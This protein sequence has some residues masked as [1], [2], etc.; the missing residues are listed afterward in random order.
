MTQA[1]A[2]ASL[3]PGDGWKAVARDAARWLAEG[4]RSGLLL[5]SRVAGEAAPAV[6]LAVALAYAALKL[7]LDRLEIVGPAQFHLR[8]WLAPHW[9]N[10][11]VAV[12]M[13]AVLWRLPGDPRRPRGLGAWFTLYFASAIPASRVGQG[14]AIAAAREALPGFLDHPVAGWSV[15]AV[16]L[17]WDT[18]VTLWLGVQFGLRRWRLA[19]AVGGWLALFALSVWQGDDHAWYPAPSARDQ[20]PRL[21]LSQEVFEQQQAAWQK[22]VDGI[23]P[24]REGVRDVYGIVFAPYA[25]EDVFLR[26]AQMVAGVL[27]QRFDATGR[28]LQLVN[29]AT[30]ATTL[31]WATP[32]NLRRAIEA[33]AARMDREHDVLVVYLTSHGGGDFHLAAGH[34]PLDVTPLTPQELRTALDEAGIRHR[35]VAVSACY[36]GGWVGPLQ[37]DGTLVMT[38]ADA[39]HTSYGCGRKSE[40]TFFGRALFHEQLR[41]TRSFEQAFAAAVPVIRQREVDARKP[42]GF[43]NPQISVDEAVRPVLEDLARRLDAAPGGTPP[44]T[45]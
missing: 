11:L 3:A 7:G 4:V 1:A 36:S 19:A 9:G 10:A 39:T 34:R 12:L 29:H 14:L 40:L 13:W 15:Y 31:P 43:S 32:L 25:H 26:E 44:A 30:T 35:V 41:Q 5:R 33:L 45:R 37:G 16:L 21:R 23:A 38:A 8:G 6:F 28:V 27:E 22:A 17:G 2:R 42:D 24:Q 20:A 18:L